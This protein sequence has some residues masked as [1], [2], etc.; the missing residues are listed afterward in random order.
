MAALLRKDGL[1]V[2][3]LRDVLS[4]RTKGGSGIGDK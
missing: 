4:S 1:G 3:A 2:V